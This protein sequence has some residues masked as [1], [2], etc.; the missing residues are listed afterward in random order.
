MI[1]G[2]VLKQS[3][4]HLREQLRVVGDVD[5]P[6]ASFSGA[7]PVAHIVGAVHHRQRNDSQAGHIE[8]CDRG[9]YVHITAQGN[10]H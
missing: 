6:S 1:S 7:E 9:T 8:G 5:H 3:S 2:Y 4:Q 10:G